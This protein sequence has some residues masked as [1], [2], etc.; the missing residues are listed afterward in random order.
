M[1]LY[2]HIET[3]CPARWTNN[4]LSWLSNN[5]TI[6]RTRSWWDGANLTI[7]HLLAGTS[8]ESA[9]WK[10]LCPSNMDQQQLSWFSNNISIT[11]S[12]SWCSRW[13]ESHDSTLIGRRL[14][15]VRNM[16]KRDLRL[17]GF[18]NN[19]SMWRIGTMCRMERNSPR[20]P[21][22]DHQSHQPN[23]AIASRMIS[24]MWYMSK[25][26]WSHLRNS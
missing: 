19:R 6:T 18:V 1:S 17:I 22:F 15:R 26:V 24:N 21:S 25:N 12:Q 11:R 3:L 8:L 13:G 20:V 14:P 2:A 7:R 5:I 16:G 4:N 9:A 10:K 23:I